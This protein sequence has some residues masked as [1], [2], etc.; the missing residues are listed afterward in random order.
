MKFMQHLEFSSSTNKSPSSP[1]KS[2][3][4]QAQALPALLGCP[5]RPGAGSPPRSPQTYK[6]MG[7][8]YAPLHSRPLRRRHLGRR[9]ARSG[10]LQPTG[11]PHRGLQAPRY[12]ADRPSHP[13][14]APT[15]VLGG[16][17]S[18][19]R[20]RGAAHKTGQSGR[21]GAALPAPPQRPR[22]KL[23]RVGPDPNRGPNG[24]P[25][26]SPAGGAAAAPG[27]SC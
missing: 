13:L 7:R 12:A 11:G 26:P 20:S 3:S 4:Y 6:E 17:G 25:R 22:A 19:G 8:P 2:S 21:R 18:R 24:L 1:V 15:G 23:G 5:P 9:A 10:R 16:R 27:V 14:P